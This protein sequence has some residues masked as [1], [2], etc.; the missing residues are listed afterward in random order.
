MGFRNGDFGMQ[1]DYHGHSHHGE[2]EEKTRVLRKIDAHMMSQMAYLID[3]LKAQ[4]DL[5]NGEGTLFDHTTILFGCGMATGPHSTKNLPLVLAG[6]GFKLGEHLVLPE[7]KSERIRASSLLLSIA[8][9]FGLEVDRFGVSSGTLR[10]LE[11]G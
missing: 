11:W 5:L 3:L 6:G 7:A 1:G 10:G 9:N 8:Q 4:P 2:R